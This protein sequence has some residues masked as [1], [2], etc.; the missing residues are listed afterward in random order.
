M[1]EEDLK[2]LIAKRGQAKAQLTRFIKFVDVFTNEKSIVELETRLHKIEHNTWD[3]FINVQSNIEIIKEDEIP[4]REIFENLFFDVVARAKEIIVGHVKAFSVQGSAKS[5]NIV[6]NNNIK[7]PTIQLPTFQGSYD[8]WLEFHDT[9]ESLIHANKQISDIQKF[10]YLKSAIRGEAAQV[11]SALEISAGNYKIAWDLICERY[12]NKRLLIQNHIK[13]LFSLQQINKESSIQ[14]RQLIDNLSKHIRSLNTLGQPTQH[15]DALLIY[16]ISNKLDKETARE[17]EAYKCDDSENIPTLEMM[18]KFLK[19]KA[20]LLETLELGRSYAH[21]NSDYK[22]QIKH[23]TQ[24]QSSHKTFLTTNSSCHYCKGQ[25]KIYRCDAFSN[26][27]VNERISH[28]QKANLCLNCL[29]VGHSYQ[30]CRFGTCKKCTSKHNTLLHLGQQ[31]S[32]EKGDE[33]VNL[34]SFVGMDNQILLSTAIIQ[35][36][37][38]YGNSHICR[39]LLDS[40]SQSNFITSNLFQSL[41][42]DKTDINIS[43]VG[44]SQVSSSIKSKCKVRIKSNQGSFS[45]SLN[46]LI[47]PNICDHMP[48]LQVNISSLNIPKHILLADKNFHK[49]SKIDML[50]GA[51]LFWQ[52]L[53]PAQIKLGP[54]QPTLHDTKFGWIISGPLN[55]STNNLSYCNLSTETHLHEQLKKFWEIEECSDDKALSLEEKEC[56]AHFISTFQRNKDGRFIVSIPLKHSIDKLGDSKRQAQNRFF[57]LE[58]KLQSNPNLC[59]SYTQFIDEY[60]AMEHMSEADSI[61]Q[62]VYYLPHHGVEKDSATTKLRVVFDGSC[63]TSTGVSINDL[64]MVGPTI[65][66]DLF[67]ILLRFRQHSYIA[68]AD[69]EKMY[70]QVLITPEQRSLQQIYWRRNPLDSLTSYQLNTVTYGTA[71]AAFLAIRCLMQLSYENADKFPEAAKT[72]ASD[73]YVDDLLTGSDSMEQLKQNCQ[74]I[75]H[76]LD[77]GC[78]PLRKWISNN[79]F[80]IQ[81]IQSSISSSNI[82]RLGSDENAKTL[83]IIWSCNSDCLL[84]NINTN[85]ITHHLTKRAI[86]SG[87]ARIYDPLG[88]LSACVI[89]AKIILQRLWLEKL[90]WDDSIP[91]NLQ[92]KWVKFREEL[93]ELNDLEIP[94]HIKCSNPV[95]LELHG[96]SDASLDAYGTCL[97]VRS[98]DQYGTIIVHLLC[99]KSKVAPLNSISIPRLELCGALIMARLT[100]KVTKSISL[101]FDDIFHWCDSTIVLGWINTASNLLKTFVS[102]RISEIQSKTNSNNWHH[103]NTKE[104]PADLL[105]RGVNPKTLKSS[106]LW[107][108]GPPWLSEDSNSWPPS[109]THS[110]SDLSEHK[111]Q[112][113]TV[114]ITQDVYEFPFPRFSSFNKL[115][116]CAAYCFRFKENCT[117]PKHLRNLGPLST[118]E[119][120][121]ASLSLVKFVQNECFASE[122]SLLKQGKPLSSK[123]KILSLNPFLDDERIIRVGGR[124]SHSKFDFN[125]KHPILL[126]SKHHFTKLLFRYEHIRLLHAGPQ[127]LLASIRDKFWPVMGRNAAKR[128][129]HECMTCF[130]V[131]PTTQINPLMGD[132][133]EERVLPS[134]PFFITGVDYAGPFHIKDRNGRGC[135]LSKAYVSLFV[136]FATKAIHLELVTDLST[137]SFIAALRR[138]VSRRGKPLQIMSDNGTNFIGANNELKNLG[139]FLLSTSNQITELNASEGIN[140]S[141]IPAY[142]PH[143]GGL[144]EAGVKSM[145]GHLKRIMGNANLTFE[146]FQTLLTQVEAILNS[147]PLSPLSSD[148]NDLDPITPAHFLIGR[149]LTAVPDPVL[150][151]I[152]ENR[153]NRFQRIQQLCQHFWSRWSSEYVNELQIRTKWRQNHGQLTVGSLVLIKDKNQP[154]LNWALGRVMDII[155]GEDNITRVVSVKSS[156]GVVRRAITSICPLPSEVK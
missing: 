26:L 9:F 23:K 116:R 100:Y 106:S 44:I 115:R 61:S 70:R 55:R 66:S 119:I 21:S 1:S 73:F 58:R 128:A 92:D 22:P 131:K 24:N 82:H 17:W 41:G 79:P 39:A 62:T 51:E 25:H 151:H 81:D 147:R 86:L 7:L 50:I 120:D 148:P 124:L 105:S 89:T 146:D 122:L 109:V 60:Q 3:E 113:Q 40:G 96:F 10:H 136:C 108:H 101:Q 76:I 111:T 54:A 118:K 99:A 27:P 132:L 110:N 156:R 52:L 130:R 53:C 56:E 125:K 144:W 13:A 28:A 138:F 42:L 45:T 71:A 139:K 29:N 14:L 93:M 103:V 149:P 37:D 57:K 15:W 154:P 133:P 80:V 83:G 34:S 98:I 88:L 31:V 67:S 140:W 12:A 123:S 85:L 36:F 104:N 97:Y 68:S 5:Q 2:L 155:P 129:V 6:E 18:K 49:P 134:P 63:P 77:Q 135:K 19:N 47:V 38:K 145:K 48:I 87:I 153:L 35:V 143:F 126:P 114:L 65:Q 84:Y 102:N 43:V 90:G 137:D 4:A 117:K 8:K 64:Q 32:P 69:V 141:F 91:I 112:S 72:I 152:K 75:S 30:E 94:R 59:E 33:S 127:Q 74:Q 142:S 46:C 78:F 107:W 95:R 11:I 20:D 121:N 16:M 150:S